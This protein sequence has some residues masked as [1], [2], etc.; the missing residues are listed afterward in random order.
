[1][2]K[3]GE[4]K[5]SPLASGPPVKEGWSLALWPQQRRP[6]QI[7]ATSTNDSIRSTGLYVHS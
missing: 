3:N 6:E 5:G 1:V 2:L 7:T 4:E